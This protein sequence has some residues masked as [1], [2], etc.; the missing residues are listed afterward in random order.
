MSNYG[1]CLSIST[2]LIF[3]TNS[4]LTM[5]NKIFCYI[6]EIV[7]F[8]LVTPVV[9][10]YTGPLTKILKCM[11]AYLYTTCA[12]TDVYRRISPTPLALSWT[13]QSC[14][15][16]ARRDSARWVPYIFLHIRV[17]FVNIATRRHNE[18]E[19]IKISQRK[20]SALGC[21]NWVFSYLAV[22]WPATYLALKQ[23]H[24]CSNVFVLF[25][26]YS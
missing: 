1:A 7:S 17:K 19:P 25:I 10:A 24:D 12:L 26:V 4:L 2:L 13:E 16:S 15:I 23:C 14:P 11:S 20:K 6:Y 5:K 3:V 8:L 18:I 21:Q 22:M 9:L